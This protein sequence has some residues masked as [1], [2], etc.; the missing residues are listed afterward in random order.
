MR[1]LFDLANKCFV[2][3]PEFLSLA[4]FCKLA[5]H[6]NNDVGYSRLILSVLSLR[7]TSCER[8]SFL[9][10]PRAQAQTPA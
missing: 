1:F 7:A 5:G 4:Q 10:V 6:E 2:S 9:C 8:S 3:A